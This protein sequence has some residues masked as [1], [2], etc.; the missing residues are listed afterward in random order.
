MAHRSA[1][2]PSLRN[3]IGGLL[4]GNVIL[5][6]FNMIP[7]LP[8]DGGRVLR[9]ALAMV[10]GR[11]RATNIAGFVGQVLAAGLVAAGLMMQDQWSW[12]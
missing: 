5:A 8:M 2:E 1:S 4:V 9:S 7:A 12:P 10:I 6:V 11:P 3:F